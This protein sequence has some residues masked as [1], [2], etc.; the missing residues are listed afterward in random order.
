MTVSA[1]GLQK[2]SDLPITKSSQT[3]RRISQRDSDSNTVQTS[4]STISIEAFTSDIIAAHS[5]GYHVFF[6]PLM[7]VQAKTSQ[8]Y[9]YCTNGIAYHRCSKGR[10]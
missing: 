5:L 9:K 7:Q 2:L 6:V 8:Q 3:T 10:S 1:A 4:Q